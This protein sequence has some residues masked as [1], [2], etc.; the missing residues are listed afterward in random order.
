MPDRDASTIPGTDP[1]TLLAHHVAVEVL[2][3]EYSPTTVFEHVC[4]LGLLG[5]LLTTS[6]YGSW[7][8]ASKL[9]RSSRRERRV[10]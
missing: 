3:R 2:G 6:A 10:S 7:T 5:L 1:M 8:L 4:L 9:S